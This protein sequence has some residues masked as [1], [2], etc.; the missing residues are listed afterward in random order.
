MTRTD[1]F[2]AQLEAYLDEHEGSTPL[3][4]VVRDAIRAELPSIHQ[5]PA[6]WPER[7]FVLMN[8]TAKFAIAAAALAVATLLGI[9]YLIAPNVGDR[10]PREPAPTATPAPDLNGQ[11]G[12]LAPGAYSVT[13]ADHLVTF[14]VPS[15]W[16]KN[17]ADSVAWTEN[18]EARVSFGQ[19]NQLSVDPCRRELGTLDVGPNVDD[20]VTALTAMPGVETATTDVTLGRFAGTRVD[21]TVPE[22]LSGCTGGEIMLDAEKPLE[23]GVHA[24]WILDVDGDTVVITAVART[25]ASDAQR[26]QLDEIIESIDID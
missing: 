10:A 8:S 21:M 2:I 23:P 18:S 26:T 4:Q 22:T 25:A 13:V 11:D 12:S 17:V 14:S 20:L 7:R 15:G 16:T 9:N 24:F 1:E 19:L 3:P 5:R 6:W